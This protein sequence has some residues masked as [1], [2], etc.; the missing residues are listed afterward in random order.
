MQKVL[1]LVSLSL[2]YET[3]QFCLAIGFIDITDLITNTSGGILGILLFML[4]KQI[5]KSRAVTVIN[6]SG[7]T[8]DLI[9]YILLG[10]F[11]IVNL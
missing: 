4:F 3:A 5:F 10:V 7:I 1:H 2:I 8:I 6:I 9:A 11:I